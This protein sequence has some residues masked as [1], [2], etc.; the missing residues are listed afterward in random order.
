LDKEANTQ[1][2]EE[3]RERILAGIAHD[4]AQDDEDSDSY[5]VGEDGLQDGSSTPA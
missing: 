4:L 3:F 5:Y 1:I 2:V